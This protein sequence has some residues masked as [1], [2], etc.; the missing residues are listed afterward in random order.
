MDWDRSA[1]QWVQQYAAGR[2][3]GAIVTMSLTG[4]YRADNDRQARKLNYPIMQYPYVPFRGLIVRANPRRILEL[5]ES[6]DLYKTKG[7]AESWLKALFG[8]HLNTPP[9][10]PKGS[11]GR[12][13]SQL[14]RLGSQTL[15]Y[16]QMTTN[17]NWEHVVGIYMRSGDRII[18]VVAQGGRN[19][20]TASVTRMAGEALRRGTVQCA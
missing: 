12:M 3:T 1:P 15:G 19:F 20:A 9:S 17:R 6:I 7:A 16:S 13:L 14:P 2:E 10:I 4:R 18:S 8:R 5:Y 11:T